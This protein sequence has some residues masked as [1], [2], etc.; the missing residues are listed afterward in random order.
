MFSWLLINYLNEQVQLGGPYVL[1]QVHENPWDE[2]ELLHFMYL[3]VFNKQ[4]LAAAMYIKVQKASWTPK[5]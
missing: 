4:T 3:S 2:H 5:I 1:R